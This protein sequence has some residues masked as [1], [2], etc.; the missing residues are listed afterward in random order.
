MTD[1]AKELYNKGVYYHKGINGFEQNYSEA[2][3]CYR[4][5]A[6]LGHSK[7][8]FWLGNLYNR[9]QGVEQSQEQ[10]LLWYTKSAELGN[11][12]A[13]LYLEKLKHNTAENQGNNLSANDNNSS[14]P[15]N[16]ESIISSLENCVRN[17]LNYMCNCIYTCIYTCYICYIREDTKCYAVQS[18][19]FLFL[20]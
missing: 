15:S 12:D 11:Q 14:S 17:I 5:A 9:G 4:E 1:N 10:A 13:K 18:F 7:A 8:A 20:F 19:L 2:A 3:K 16:S 6:E